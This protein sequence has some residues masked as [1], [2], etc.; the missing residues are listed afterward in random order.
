MAESFPL[1]CLQF[2]WKTRLKMLI[3]SWKLILDF[4]YNFLNAAPNKLFLLWWTY[5]NRCK[6]AGLVHPTQFF[7]AV[8][9]WLQ[10]LIL[11]HCGSCCLTLV[12]SYVFAHAFSILGP[13]CTQQWTG[14]WSSPCRL[15][16]FTFM[17]RFLINVLQHTGQEN[18]S[19]FCFS[20]R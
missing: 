7:T 10:K 14:P 12:I 11:G 2:C 13:L 3:F 20:V 4:P 17:S 5:S 1:K 6:A 8:T 18:I 9:R 16:A 19:K 15:Q